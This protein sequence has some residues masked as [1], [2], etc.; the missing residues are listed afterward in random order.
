MDNLDELYQQVQQ[1]YLQNKSPW[2]IGYSGGKDSTAVLQLVWYALRGLPPEQRTK[3]VYVLTSDTLVETPVIVN[4]IDE[5]LGRIDEAASAANMPF[6]AHKVRPRLQDTFWVNLIGKGYPAPYSKF[7]WCT[8]RLKI[9]PANTFILDCVAKYGEVVVIL[10]IRTAESATRAQ[11][12]SL[13]KIKD[14]VL[15]RHSTLPNAF[16]YA[17]IED[18]STDDVWSYL[19]NVQSPWGNQNRDLL[20]M[21]RNAQAGEC[22]LVVDTT[23]PSCGNSRFGCWVCTVVQKDRTMEALI[24]NGE[25]WL[26]P[27]LELRDFLASTQVPEN[28]PLYRDHKRRSGKVSFTSRGT[29]A[30]GPYYLDV[31]KEILRRLLEAQRSVSSQSEGQDVSLI[32][33][34]ELHEIRRI[35]RTERQDWSDSVPE[36]YREVTG[37]D[38][39]WVIDDSPNFSSE[40]K[41]MLKRLCERHDI[42][43]EL[44]AKLLDAERQYQ[45]MN[46][47]AGILNQISKILEEEWRGEEEMIDTQPR[48]V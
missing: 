21:Y 36:I 38:L 15:R 13:R 47:R 9:Q 12:M 11:S 17:P 41:E 1:V 35:W 42:P 6:Q 8:D 22:P 2:V 10:G 23:T 40:D 18:F 4:Y 32:S 3:P 29:I 20:A 5:T 19:L 31:C 28:K 46:R 33:E 24:D 30:R 39:E 44:V 43:A 7:R 26:E 45:G 48:L 25:E 16:V 37:A 27:L 34:A 14:S